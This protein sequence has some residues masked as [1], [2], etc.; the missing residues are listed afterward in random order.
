MNPQVGLPDLNQTNQI[1]Q[2]KVVDLMNKLIDIGVAGF[3]IDA[4]KHMWP[5]DLN[6]IF[7]RLNNLHGTYFSVNSKPYIYQEVIDNGGEAIK[8]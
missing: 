2:D 4:A 1:V 6:S 3:R 5:A 8:K 7:S